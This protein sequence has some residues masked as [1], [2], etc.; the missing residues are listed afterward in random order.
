LPAPFR[1]FASHAAA[2]FCIRHA[3]RI[4]RWHLLFV[5]V[6]AESRLNPSFI[7]IIPSFSSH[8]ERLNPSFIIPSFLY[9]HCYVIGILLGYYWVIIG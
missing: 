1:F 2:R 7:F 5:F 3:W 8:S 4:G 6:P 9:I